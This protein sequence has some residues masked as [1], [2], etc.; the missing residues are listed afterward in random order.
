MRGNERQLEV[1]SAPATNPGP[2]IAQPHGV[3]VAEQHVVPE[4]EQAR[5]RERLMRGAIRRHPMEEGRNQM[6]SEGAIRSLRA[7]SRSRAA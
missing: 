3:R 2:R 6:Q 5:R 7:P 1:I 4:L